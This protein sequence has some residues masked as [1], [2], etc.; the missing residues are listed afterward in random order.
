MSRK[1]PEVIVVLEGRVPPGCRR[2]LEDFLREARGYYEQPG[3]IRVRLL[4]DLD[5]PDRFR[6]VIEYAERVDYERDDDRVAGDPVMRGY[7]ERWHALLAEPPRVRRWGEA[8]L[9]D[10][11]A[12][13]VTALA[14]LGRRSP[15]RQPAA[16]ITWRAFR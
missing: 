2:Q 14:D 9:R 15:S 5:D 4:W 11:A 13:G 10:P 12:P 7:L 16:S 1:R 3:G 6:E 8:D